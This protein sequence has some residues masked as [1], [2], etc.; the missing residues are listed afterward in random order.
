M[1][2]NNKAE[3]KRSY[4][5][6]FINKR[7]YNI[8][9]QQARDNFP[10]ESGGFLGGTDAGFI[11]G[12]L[13]IHNRKVGDRTKEFEFS[14]SDVERAHAFFKKH[15]LKYY[16][17]YHTHPKGAPYPSHQDIMS[18]HKYHFIMS[19]SDS[20]LPIFVAFH[21]DKRKAIP[22]PLMVVENSNSLVDIH[23][24][25]IDASENK[26]LLKS[27]KCLKNKKYLLGMKTPYEEATMLKDIVSRLKKGEKAYPILPSNG[28]DKYNDFSTVA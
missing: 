24:K 5:E 18:G 16:G 14:I 19:I 12:I 26:A 7:H 27:K 4:S 6:F 3:T 25:N 10:C 20:E 28:Y 21:V 1:K 22:V 17:L 15:N 2:D 13:P 23:R 11:L 8:I 9:L